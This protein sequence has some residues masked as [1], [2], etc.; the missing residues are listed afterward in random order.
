MKWIRYWLQLLNW[1][2]LRQGDRMFLSPFD[3]YLINR[4]GYDGFRKNQTEWWDSMRPA[5]PAAQT[6][7]TK[8]KP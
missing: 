3:I 6:Q 8:E 7:E 5:T 2:S 4:L 1:Y